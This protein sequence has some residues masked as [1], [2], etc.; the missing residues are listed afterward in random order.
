MSAVTPLRRPK[1]RQFEAAKVSLL[2]S[3]WPTITRPMDVELRYGLRALRHRC[4][5]EAQNSDT[6]KAYLRLL[7]NNVIGAQG[8]GLQSLA[9][10]G[11]GL[12]ARRDR[13]MLEAEWRDWNRAGNCDV[14][15][16]LSGCDVD[17]LALEC[18]ARDGEVLLRLV[19]GWENRWNFAIQIIDPEQLDVDYTEELGPN[20]VV[21]MGVELNQWR[22][23]LAYYLRK[24]PLVRHGHDLARGERIRVPAAE[25]VHAYR[26]EWVWQTR[27]VPWMH[28]G[29]KTLQHTD[30]YIEAAVVAARKGASAMGFYQQSLDAEPLSDG[31]GEPR[32]GVAG[33]SGGGMHEL[34]QEFEPGTSHVLPPGMT[35][36][37][38][39]PAFP[40][41]D[42][43]PFVQAM[44]QGFASGTGVGY[45]ALAN[46]WEGVSYNSLRASALVERDHYKTVQRW[47]IEAVKGRVFDAWLRTSILNGAI[48][49]PTSVPEEQR[50][51]QLSRVRW[52]PRRW[53]WVDPA[54][55]IE[56]AERAVALRVRSISSIIR[57]RGDDPDEVF[58]EIAEERRRLAELGL[59]PS[60]VMA[61]V[62]APPS[63]DDENGGDD[64]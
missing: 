18:A 19:T 63:N 61:A 39:D 35:W 4:R 45:N 27:G 3:D 22:R 32:G 13:S 48:P 41:V 50:L 58:E 31:D 11:R 6:V 53:D 64:A 28:T 1:Q 56:A 30:G 37:G 54:K 38:W 24:Q 14:T 33:G 21:V 34:S 44:L 23:P 20:R 46:D 12:A 9:V 52:Q 15:G 55:D 25:I 57:E 5:H 60:D 47:Y 40:N 26:P 7:K 51:E 17:E 2:T 43:G 10:N 36:Q 49:R 16:S 59:T 42:H 62:S 8:I 29:I